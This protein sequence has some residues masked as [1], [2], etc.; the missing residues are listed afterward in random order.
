M[1]KQKPRKKAPGDREGSNR[2]LGVNTKCPRMK[3]WPSSGRPGARSS[4]RRWRTWGLG[5]GE[6]RASRLTAP[7]GLHYG[8]GPLADSHRPRRGTRDGA[9]RWRRDRGR[10]R[11]L[12][13]CRDPHG[14]LRE[15][16]PGGPSRFPQAGAGG[17]TRK[18][19]AGVPSLPGTGGIPGCLTETV[20][21]SD[22][23]R[24]DAE[25]GFCGGAFPVRRR[26]AGLPPKRSGGLGRKLVPR[27]PT[28]RALCRCRRRATRPAVWSHGRERS[29]RL[30]SRG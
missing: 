8:P 3:N 28:E 11:D 27:E 21:P 26:R 17:F 7:P 24:N 5:A 12:A 9:G 20:S 13:P 22:A 6:L 18:E 30:V 23:A 16:I 4:G 10:A 14:P 15:S 25:P 29:A 1:D 19:K 2:R